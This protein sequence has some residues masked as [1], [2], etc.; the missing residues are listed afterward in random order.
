M[1]SGGSMPTLR[2]RPRWSGS[3]LGLCPGR[4]Y[5]IGI[6]ADYDYDRS[7]SDEGNNYSSGVSITIRAGDL[8][9]SNLS[10]NDSNP[11]LGD[12]VTVSWTANARDD[13]PVSSTQQGVM[14]SNDTP[15]QERHLLGVRTPR[16]PRGGGLRIEPRTPHDHDPGQP[17]ARGHLPLPWH[18][19]GLQQPGHR[20]QRG[21]QRSVA[22]SF[23]PRG[24][25][26]EAID[27]AATTI[28][29]T[30]KSESIAT[31]PGDSLFL[32]SNRAQLW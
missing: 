24:P 20:I 11:D 7:E 9:A 5:W 30:E 19:H 13:I 16:R 6:Y 3:P 31:W 32:E 25:D 12:L 29:L 14:L 8:Y 10:I 27:L 26:L 18:H 2:P 21:Q 17:H 1:V 23:T 4:I 28:P 22:G 15:S